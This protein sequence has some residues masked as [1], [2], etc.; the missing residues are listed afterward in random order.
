MIVLLLWRIERVKV[1]YRD[2]GARL[3]DIEKKIACSSC[4][5]SVEIVIL[6]DDSYGS[7]WA[8]GNA[9]R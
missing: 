6:I 2:F 8:V 3:E 1:W 9:M 7:L 5:H 4:V